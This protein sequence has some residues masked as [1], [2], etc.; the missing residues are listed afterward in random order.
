[1][2]KLGIENLLTEEEEALL[3][4]L[5]NLKEIP[6]YEISPKLDETLRDYQKNGHRWIQFLYEHQ[7]GA[8]LADDMGLG[9]TIQVISFLQSNPGK[10][11]LI[12]CPVSILLNWQ[13]EFKKFS[14]LPIQIY[15]GPERNLSDEINI[16]LTSYGVLKKEYNHEFFRQ[17]FDIMV[18]DEVQMLKN[19][20]SLGAI[21]ARSLN[22]NFT[23]CLTGTPVE[24]EIG[25][26]FNI[27][28]LA[29]PGLWGNIN[30]VKT[31][32][33]LQEKQ[34]V[35]HNAKPFILRRTKDQVL[36]D[37]PEKIEQQSILSFSKEEQNFY[38]NLKEVIKAEIQEAPKNRKYGLI[39]R[40][41][42]KLRQS[43]LWQPTEI[44]PH[45][46]HEHHLHAPGK[47]SSKIHFLLSQLEQIILEG[48]QVL[49]FSQFTSY[50]DL[51]QQEVTSR[52]WKYSRID[53]SYNV[54]KRQKE[55]KKF[56]DGETQV[57]LISLKAG[58]VG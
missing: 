12:A 27:M 26:F 1:M 10:K 56:Q 39:L 3:E 5:T 6:Q 32:K 15:H 41:L 45:D 17:N 18:L 40:G 19:I 36:D 34:I 11:V 9:K 30:S 14:N 50:L 48:H 52:H 37:L 8:C 55:I 51:I 24:N 31:K 46:G 7:F 25:E 16:T 57:F 21:A 13:Q 43:C 44:K 54:N 35:R 53:G 42:L 23:I 58:G 28:D 4:Q 20:R 38:N 33:R 49:V 2:K 47:L 29:V 22:A